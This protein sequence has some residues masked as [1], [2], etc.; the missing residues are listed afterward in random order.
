M[1]KSILALSILGVTFFSVGCDQLQQVGTEVLNT[2]TSSGG[3]LTTSEIASGLKEALKKGSGNAVSTLSKPGGYLNNQLIKIPFP[4]EA[5]FAADKL[6]QI[7]M[8]NTVDNFVGSL[9]TAAEGAATQAKPIFWDAIKTMSFADAMG[10]LKGGDN[11]ATN[12]F[13]SKTTA[14]LVSAFAPKINEALG[15]NNTT[16]HWSDLTSAYNAIPLTNQKVETDLSAYATNKALD[17][18]FTTLA[19]EEKLI[20]DN[21]A[22]RTSEILKKVFG[23]V[24]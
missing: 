15:K 24:D 8:G 6:R 22:A 10:I 7:G 23:S 3:G 18:L 16:K 2:A 20:R 19:G 11:A 13:K 1:K 17:G 12:Y 9:N 4:P 21:P 14:Q 5:K